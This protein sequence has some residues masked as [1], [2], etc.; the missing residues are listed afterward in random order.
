MS[1]GRQCFGKHKGF[2]A[3]SLANK[4]VTCLPSLA[5]GTW[6][7]LKTLSSWTSAAADGKLELPN[8]VVRWLSRSMLLH[9]KTT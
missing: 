2:D 4:P 7:G 8:S 3:R 1:V 6:F 9:P 5:R